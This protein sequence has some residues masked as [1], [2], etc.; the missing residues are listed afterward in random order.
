MFVLDNNLRNSASSTNLRTHV[1]AYNS[2]DTKTIRMTQKTPSQTTPS[3]EKPCS[4]EKTLL[5]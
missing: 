4:T 3:D 2:F 5:R 1:L